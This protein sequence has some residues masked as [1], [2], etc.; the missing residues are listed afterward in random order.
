MC[1]RCA[2]N[3]ARAALR[4]AR[5]SA[6][7][8]VSG[9]LAPLLG[10]RSAALRSR[11]SVPPLRSVANRFLA[12]LVPR[13]VAPLR[14]LSLR[15]ATF[16]LAALARYEPRFRSP[17]SGLRCSLRCA[18]RLRARLARSARSSRMLT[19]FAVISAAGRKEALRA[20][21]KLALRAR[22]WRTAIMRREHGSA[23]SPASRLGIH[24]RES[25]SSRACDTT[26]ADFA[27]RFAP[28]PPNARQTAG[29][30][31]SVRSG[32][33][34]HACASV[35]PTLRPRQTPQTVLRRICPAQA[36]VTPSFHLPALHSVAQ[37]TAT[38]SAAS[39][40]HCVPFRS[41]KLRRHAN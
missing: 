1:A 25:A 2:R 6:N 20:Q 19:P 29:F 3:S 34:A 11:T 4:S 7:S 16:R 14:A 21:T 23:T 28:P 24:W 9:S 36:R 33:D 40:L 35:P 32:Y 27:A 5:R 39:P 30:G 13:A 37:P 22:C 17:R 38:N 10:D 31:V 18:P 12:A 41:L 8:I 15:S 26:L